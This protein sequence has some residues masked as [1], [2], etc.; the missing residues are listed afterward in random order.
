MTYRNAVSEQSNF[1]VGD[2]VLVDRYGS[3]EP[4]VVRDFWCGWVV[5]AVGGADGAPPVVTAKFH[6]IMRA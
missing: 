2:A 6:R 1:K 5:V 4:A 3:W